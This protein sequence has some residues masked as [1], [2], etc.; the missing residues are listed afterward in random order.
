M[1]IV[2]CFSGVA[3]D[4][5]IGAFLDFGLDLNALKGELA[6]LPASGYRLEVERVKRGSIYG[7]KFHVRIGSEEHHAHR[8]YTDI[9]AM[10]EKSPLSLRVK[11]EALGIFAKV[12]EAEARLHNTTISEVTFHKVG[13]IDS[14]VDI[15]GSA[16]CFDL[17]GIDSAYASEIPL[18]HSALIPDP[19]GHGH[20]NLPA[21]APATLEI[22]K[23]VPVRPAMRRAELVTPTG[24]AIVKHFARSFGPIPPMRLEGVGYG[25]GDDDFPDMPNLLR[26]MVGEATGEYLM[27]TVSIIET[28]I[29]D[30][31]PQFYDNLM[32]RLL[33]RGA[34]DVSLAPLQ[35]KKGRPGVLL[36]VISPE[37]AREELARTIFQESTAAGIRFYRADRYKLKREEVTLETRF[38][39][40]RGKLLY[41]PEGGPTIQPEYEDCLRLAEELDI[42]L[43]EVYKEAMR[44][45]ICY[46]TKNEAQA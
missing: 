35:M 20:G 4:M 36:K 8:H 10:I 29:D 6:K 9:K 46:E 19:H 23:G 27:D 32:E 11:E 2:Y 21:P 25:A 45:A 39:K 24:A 3:G 38:G 44:S 37:W 1:R 40:I 28:N 41:D 30:M 31:N 16:I 26:V 15:V 22:L 18:G 5:V 14:I 43:K 13:A 33:S 34:L 17:L 12:A 42:P 7:S